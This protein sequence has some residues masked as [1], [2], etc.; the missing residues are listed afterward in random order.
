MTNLHTT[1]PATLRP[2][3]SSDYEALKRLAPMATHEYSDQVDTMLRGL[4]DKSGDSPT[5]MQGKRGRETITIQVRHQLTVAERKGKAVGMFYF[6]NPTSWMNE[7]GGWATNELTSMVPLINEIQMLAVEPRQRRRGI[8]QA[9]LDEA[10]HHLRATGHRLVMVCLRKTGDYSR[11]AD[12]YRRCGYTFGPEG[13]WST[14][15]PLDPTTWHPWRMHPRTDDPR[16]FN[17]LRG[18]MPGYGIGFKPLHPAVAVD[19]ATATITGL[20]DG[21]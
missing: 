6:G 17:F 11:L 9:L 13:D 16:S 15:N 18:E 10:E 19:A 12:W 2:P 3:Q 21:A 5:M 8:G 7:L 4:C 1:A 20:M 14:Y